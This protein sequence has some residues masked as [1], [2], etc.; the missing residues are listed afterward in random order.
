MERFKEAFGSLADPRAANARHELWELLVVALAA[1]LCGAESCADMEAANERAGKTR[2][3]NPGREYRKL[4]STHDPKTAN[5][6]LDKIGLNRKD[7]EGYRLRT[8]GKGRL[9]IEVTTYLGF[10]PFTQI[11][12][13]I[14]QQWRTIGIQVLRKRSG[15][16]SGMRGNRTFIKRPW[17]LRCWSFLC[18]RSRTLASGVMSASIRFAENRCER[19]WI[20]SGCVGASS[21]SCPP[22]SSQACSTVRVPSSRPMNR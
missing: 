13:M 4:W 5:A 1:V 19:I 10:M 8:D 16:H 15:S 18:R 14:K 2:P 11:A 17:S 21:A 3:Y 22:Q 9:R 12:E 7:G 6:M 20:T